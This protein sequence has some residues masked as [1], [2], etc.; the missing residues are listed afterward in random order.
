MKKKLLFLNFHPAFYPPKSGGELRYWHLATRLARDFSVRM[1][2]PTYG[3]AQQELI[4]HAPDCVE[5]RFP[6]ARVYNAWHHFLDRW[7]KFQEC[8][9]LVSMLAAKHDSA[10]RTA[11]LKHAAEADF[12]VHSSPFVFPVYPRPKAGQFF[13]Y[14]SY[15]VES[16]LAREAFKTGRTPFRQWATRYVATQERALC[17]RADLIFCCSKEDAD[18]FA[19]DYGVDSSKMMIVPN[20]VGTAE[21]QPATPAERSAARV[22]LK[23]KEQPA[24]LFF[25]SFH[26]PNV[27]ALRFIV[28][29]VAPGLPEVLFLI[30]GK[31]CQAFE[32]ERVPANVRLLGLVSEETKQDLLQGVD[33]ALNPMF[34]G[35]GTNLKMLEY[36]ACGLPII[37]TPLGARGLAMKNDFHGSVVEAK[38]F[39]QAIQD[40]SLDKTKCKL[41]GKNARAKAEAEFDWDQIAERCSSVL[42]L[43]TSK[44]IFMLNDYPISPVAAGG[45]IRLYALGK[46][47]SASGHNVT[48]LTL[49]SNDTGAHTLHDNRFEEINI[50]RGRIQRFLDQVISGILGVSVDDICV[51]VVWKYLPI[52]LM[53]SLPSWFLV[54][55]AVNI[56]RAL[57]KADSKVEL[58]I[59][60][61]CYMVPF[62]SKSFRKVPRFYESHNVEFLLKEKL[63]PKSW[64]GRFLISQTRLMEKQAIQ[65]SKRFTTV[66]EEDKQ[67]FVAEFGISPECVV[68]ASNGVECGAVEPMSR[69]E[70]LKARAAVGLGT[71]PLFVFL[72]SGH[73][74]NAEAARFILNELCWHFKHGTF[75]II[76]SVNGWF[77]SSKI[78]DHVIFT[79]MLDSAVKDF[80]LT[81]SD[82]ALNPL[83]AGSGSSLKVPEYLRAGLPVVSTEL[84]AR[85]FLLGPENGIIVSDLQDF[86]KPM[87][88]LTKNLELLDQVS[89]AARKRALESYD[90]SKT[91]APLQDVVELLT[92]DSG[93][94]KSSS[95]K[96]SIPTKV[97]RS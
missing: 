23:L 47:L 27:E 24:C 15:N 18:F 56:F 29:R 16:R 34:S 38:F 11:V 74:P 69:A 32:G 21:L 72:G 60:N 14:D 65:L 46:S 62:G 9:G 64:L 8:S 20:G 67:T 83:M 70:K 61:H 44:R 4:T 50:P 88:Q 7:A 3:D 43:R 91:L 26:P 77:H 35:S 82:V 76:G 75:L 1:I 17:R 92:S 63:Y 89:K 33:L 51:A 73:P 97:I 28:E 66:S 95:S 13:V 71:E 6:K 54:P 90:W 57:Q 2:N 58:I 80:L 37:S 87:D 84:G 53:S 12:V 85:G 78:P 68:V 59:F 42:T 31:V 52:K 79:G 49:T 94:Q 30:A 55:S 39:Q 22:R 19:A 93:L 81:V 36:L 10:Y 96:E 86:H 48:A 40:L 25:G 5:E 45:Q 41:Y